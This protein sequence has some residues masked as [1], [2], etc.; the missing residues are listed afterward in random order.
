[1]EKINKRLIAFGI[2]VAVLFGILIIQLGGMTLSDTDSDTAGD[3]T[4]RTIVLKGDR[5]K[6]LDRNGQILAYNE[7][8]YDIEFLRDTDN[9]T[10]TGRALDTEIIQDTIEIIEKKRR[11]N[12]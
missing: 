1:M 3:R 9:R 10:E 6:I 8:S 4:L 11:Y 2:A 7:K 5:G 12:D